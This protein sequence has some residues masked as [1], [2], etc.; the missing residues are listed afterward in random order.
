MIREAIKLVVERKELSSELAEGAMKEI[1]NGTATPAQ[2]AALLTALRVK[3][4]TTMEIIAFAKVMRKF[5]E[6]INPKGTLVDT[7]GTGGDSKKTFNVSTAAAFVAAGAG[8]KIA[9]HGNLSVT[10]KCG[11]ADVLEE[12]GVNLDLEPQQVE[13]CIEQ[14][15]I[16]FMFA[17]NFHP[18]MKHALPVRKELGIRTVFNLLGPLTNPANAGAQ[19][20]GVFDPGLTETLAEVLRGLGTRHA[21]VVHSEGM[22]ELGL[23]KTKVS[24]LK[25]GQ[26]ETYFLDAGELGFKNK[27]IQESES[28]AE[29]ILRILKGAKGPERDIVVLNA[30]TTIYVGGRAETIKEGVGLAENSIDSGKALEKLNL[31]RRFEADGHT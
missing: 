21:L 20:L 15:G 13:R 16:G 29:T 7:C 8:V 9:K 26:I 11:S 4:E 2:I 12:L 17:P 3:G 23:G 22:D 14:I 6:H 1:M 24:E 18:A 30:A 25:N 31:L 27:D 10:S 28:S 19:V 5:C